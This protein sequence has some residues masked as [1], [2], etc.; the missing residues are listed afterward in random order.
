MSGEVRVE[1]GMV[2]GEARVEGEGGSGE[3]RV[4]SG[5]VSEEAMNIGEPGSSREDEPVAKRLR[6]SDISAMA[7][8]PIQS[9]LNHLPRDDMQHVAL[10]LYT[11]LPAIFGIQKTNAAVVVGEIL[12]ENEKNNQTLG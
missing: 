1:G 8:E 10:L 4:E 12:H 6:L 7:D 2:S 11:K 3:V 5:M 9:W